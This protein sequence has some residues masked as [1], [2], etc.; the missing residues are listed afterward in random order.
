LKRQLRG[1]RLRKQK[2]GEVIEES[3]TTSTLHIEPIQ[4]ERNVTEE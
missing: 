2:R 4:E 1:T 3:S